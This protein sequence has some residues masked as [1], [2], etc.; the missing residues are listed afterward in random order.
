MIKEY[1]QSVLDSNSPEFDGFR[2]NFLSKKAKT[3]D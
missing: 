2:I 1:L 3:N